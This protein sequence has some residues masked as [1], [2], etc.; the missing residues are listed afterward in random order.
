MMMNPLM[1]KDRVPEGIEQLR[2][3]ATVVARRRQITEP[4]DDHNQDRAQRRGLD[5]EV[6]RAH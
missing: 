5:K 1:G 3:E 2:M 6:R 4:A